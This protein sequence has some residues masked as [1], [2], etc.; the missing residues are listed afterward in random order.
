MKKN[1]ILIF[2]ES[3]EGIPR[4]VSDNFLDS[5]WKIYGNA[6]IFKELS[7]RFV[8]NRYWTDFSHNF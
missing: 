1:F 2:A 8:G 6:K 7:G 5:L 3:I 4:S